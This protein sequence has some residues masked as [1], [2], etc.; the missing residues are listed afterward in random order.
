MGVPE[1]QLLKAIHDDL[2]ARWCQ[3][4]DYPFPTWSDHYPTWNQHRQDTD[5]IDEED[6]GENEEEVDFDAEDVADS[7]AALRE[8]FENLDFYYD[9]DPA[10]ES[11]E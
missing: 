3:G 2:A 10:E 5:D 4:S 8:E 11:D 6:I 9:D 7:I 1:E